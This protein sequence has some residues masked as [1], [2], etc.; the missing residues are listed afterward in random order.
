VVRNL[1]YVNH[2]ID[3]PNPPEYDPQHPDVNLRSDTIYDGAGQA[4]GQRDWFAAGDMLLSRTNRTYYDALGR[5]VL[6]L[7]NLESGWDVL[8]PTPPTCNRD[9]TGWSA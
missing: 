9:A 7:R 6:A 2:P 3:N 5:P 8:N 1:D 4:V